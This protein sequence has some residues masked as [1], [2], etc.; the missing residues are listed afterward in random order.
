MPTTV[1][2]LNRVDMTTRNRL[3][4]ELASRRTAVGYSQ[5]GLAAVVG[6]H[7]NSVM[8]LERRRP[9]NPKCST[10][11]TYGNAL[12]L[13]LHLDLWDLPVPPCSAGDLFEAADF[14]GE[15][16]VARLRATREHMGI[17]RNQ[18]EAEHGWR[19]SALAAFENSTDSPML[20][21]I[22][23]LARI[24][25]GSINAWWEPW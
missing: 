20:A 2:D 19:M 1:M 22:Q 11:Q 4:T 12:R 6:V 14:L 8:T 5:R 13:T 25:G 3:V 7:R 21:Q 16:A 24:L 18:I 17:T 23:R 10:L 9:A 15:A